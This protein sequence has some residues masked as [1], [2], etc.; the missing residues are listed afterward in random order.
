VGPRVN[1]H[2]VSL[3]YPIERNLRAVAGALEKPLGYAAA[4]GRETC[5]GPALCSVRHRACWRCTRLCAHAPSLQ[6]VADLVVP[7]AGEASC[8]SRPHGPCMPTGL[9]SPQGCA[10]PCAAGT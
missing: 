7:E 1:P 6:R 9:A 8:H 10:R 5:R 3:L 4:A 2:M